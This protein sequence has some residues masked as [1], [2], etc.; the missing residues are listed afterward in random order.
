MF[1]K[2]KSCKA[3]GEKLYTFQPMGLSKKPVCLRGKHQQINKIHLLW[4]PVLEEEYKALSQDTKIHCPWGKG[5]SKKSSNPE[6]ES[7]NRLIPIMITYRNLYTCTHGISI[8]A[9]KELD[10]IQHSCVIKTV[11]ELWREEN[12]FN[13]ISRIIE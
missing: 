4:P 13:L 1:Y 8:V 11:S 5:R 7:G 12:F 10:K 3:L 2:V 9:E 6:K